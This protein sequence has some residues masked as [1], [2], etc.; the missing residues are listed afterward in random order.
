MW[1]SMR[2]MEM[3]SGQQIPHCKHLRLGASQGDT[4]SVGERF[5]E[6]L[7]DLH[8]ALKNPPPL[9]KNLPTPCSPYQTHRLKNPPPLVKK[10]PSL[11]AALVF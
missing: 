6:L 9:L 7:T 8:K 1:I 10:L 5:V 3:R 2:D 4:D 11:L